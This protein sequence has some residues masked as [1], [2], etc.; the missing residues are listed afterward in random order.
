[1]KKSIVLFVLFLSISVLAVPSAFFQDSS[2]LK[3]YLTSLEISKGLVLGTLKDTHYAVS[4]LENLQGPLT[5]KESTEFCSNVKQTL[6]KKTDIETIYHATSIAKILKC[7]LPSVKAD[8]VV[9]QTLEN[10]DATIEEYFYAL[11]SGLILSEMELFGFDKKGLEDI[12]STIDSLGE[13]DGT[14]ANSKSQ[15][16][17]LYHTGLALESLAIIAGISG[18]DDSTISSIAANAATVLQEKLVKTARGSVYMDSKDSRTAFKASFSL[19]K[20]A[21]ELFTID[22][23]NS[24]SL[25]TV[26]AVAEYAVS[27][28][29]EK[30]LQQ[31]Y[32]LSSL[33]DLLS[34]G[35]LP[36]P[37]VL[38]IPQSSFEV[39]KGGD[40]S[41]KVQ[42]TDLFG[43]PTEELKVFLLQATGANKKSIA[44]NVKL[45]PVSGSKVDYELSIP[46]LRNEQGLY[47]LE[48]GAQTS[49]K[50]TAIST[51][52]R[53]I[54][55]LSSITVSSVE[56]NIVDSGDKSAVQTVVASEEKPFGSVKTTY[57]YTLSFNFQVKNQASS[58]A[59]SV[60]QAFIRL[61]GSKSSITVPAK[62]ADNSYRADINLKN[63][64]A[65]LGYHSG[66][67][68]I[69]LIV[70]DSFVVNPKLAKLGQIRIDFP[71]NLEGKLA[72]G[73]EN[74]YAT[75]NEIEHKFRVP[76]KRPVESVSLAFTA[77]SL[78]PFL[79]LLFSLL[80]IG[81]NIKIVPDFSFIT[82]LLFGT[83]I[84]CTFTLYGWFW[85][86]L[87]MFQTLG[88]LGAI[89]VVSVLAGNRALS[90]R[91]ARRLAASKEKVQ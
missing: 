13:H 87:T 77:A 10:E 64:G 53:K 22:E 69:E 7:T 88:Y 50:K 89:S 65:D 62:F 2:S 37:L 12:V 31:I 36:H 84:I 30:D 18:D 4:S 82:S 29:P 86:E 46:S 80:I 85:Y 40:S 32:Y 76:E 48:L 41:I 39:V 14:I 52:V 70:G 59:V 72:S 27:T 33:L 20:G 38:A 83:S 9:K 26:E 44:T 3:Q 45:F 78:A 28:Q 57:F 23:E 17:T 24:I 67:Y 63:Y 42:V 75:K 58:K 81:T 1:M 15:S 34:E 43:R 71:K 56:L 47:T 8:N 74:V 19:L 49:E 60:E 55:L 91:H 21:S 54:K 66:E 16:G 25:E 90:A 68:T 35:N 61:A 79:L 51:A 6:D 11:K 5:T 73:T